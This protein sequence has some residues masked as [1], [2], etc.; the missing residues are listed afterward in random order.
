MPGGASARSPSPTSSA[1]APRAPRSSSSTYARRRS[2]AA[3]TSPARATSARASSSGTSSR[4]CPTPTW[5]STAAAASARRSPPMRSRR[6]A[7]RGGSRWTAAGGRGRRR[8]CRSS[9]SREPPRASRGGDRV[10]RLR[11]LSKRFGKVE[12]VR[13]LDLEIPSGQLVGL[14]GPNGAGKSTTVKMLTGM[15]PPS[16]GTA[17]VFG[18]DVVRDPVAV[19]RLVGY[20]PESGAVFEALTGWEYLM[21]VAALYHLPE[22]EA[23]ARVGRFGEFFELTQDTLR[24]KALGAYSKG[25]RQKVVITAA[26]LHHPQVVF[27]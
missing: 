25:M 23:E 1:C 17:E 15:L 2:G 14:L 11:Q 3:A 19:K 18:L 10:I 5:C 16:A 21:L 13:G 12:A 4:P 8:G 9:G 24:G 26:L 20:V 27:F 7:T 22:D 6:W